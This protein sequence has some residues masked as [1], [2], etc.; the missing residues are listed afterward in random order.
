MN[1]ATPFDF[2]IFATS[3][4]D[5]TAPGVA[6]LR[7]GEA[8]ADVAVKSAANRISEAREL[9]SI[10][11][12][13]RT[14]FLLQKGVCVA[15][16]RSFRL[17]GARVQGAVHFYVRSPPK[18][19]RAGFRRR[20]RHRSTSERR[21]PRAACRTRRGVLDLRRGSRQA[22]WSGGEDASAAEGISFS[23]KR[24]RPERTSAEHEKWKKPLELPAASLLPPIAR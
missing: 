6:A 16:A 5:Q 22:G 4:G 2:A 21:G 13:V 11:G 19:G 15:E 14:S 3:A 1:G 8:V 7:D 17:A 9:H 23:T 10:A 18:L 24:T 12:R 20:G